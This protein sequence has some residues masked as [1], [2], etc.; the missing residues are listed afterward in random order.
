MVLSPELE[1]LLLAERPRLIRLCAHLSGNAY[2]AEDLAQEALLQACRSID[3]LHSAEQVRPWLSAIARNVC[4]HWSRSNRRE[5]SYHMLLLQEKNMPE[6]PIDQLPSDFDLEY[7]LEREELVLL[8]DR[9]LAL[10][11]PDI[12]TVLVQKYVE[13]LPQSEIA[14]RLGVSDTT[15]AV[16]IHRGKIAFRR[17]LATTLRDEA[18]TYGLYDSANHWVKTQMWCLYCGQ[19]RLLLRR[20]H[21]PATIAFRCPHCTP[22]PEV[23]GSFFRLENN[24]FGQLF[25]QRIRPSSIFNRASEWS[26]LYFTDGLAEH[27]VR[28]THCDHQIPLQILGDQATSNDCISTRFLFAECLVCGE[29][30]SQSFEGYLGAL[31]EVQRFWRTYKR[32]RTLPYETINDDGELVVVARFEPVH[33]SARLH[34]AASQHTFR[35]LRIDSHE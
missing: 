1:T 9:A 7:L 30:V 12:Q 26:H 13:E 23:P 11:P 28:C 20:E 21:A 34:V 24:L 19:A 18:A 2:A 27:L 35:T 14:G 16:R 31:P 22:N 5:Q 6:H 3:R 10:L 15:L 8:L 4:L 25:S 32:I 33:G 29:Q 17:V